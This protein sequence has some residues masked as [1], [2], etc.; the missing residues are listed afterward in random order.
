MLNKRCIWTLITIVAIG[1]LGTNLSDNFSVKASNSLQRHTQQEIIDYVEAH[2]F[3]VNAP[4]EYEVEPDLDNFN[5]GEISDK[6]KT[7]GINAINVMRY[8]AGLDEVTLDDDYNSLTAYGSMINSINRTLTHFPTQPDGMSDDIYKLCYKGTSSSNISYNWH[9]IA[10][11][12]I[13]CMQDLSRES[14][15]AHLGHRRWILYPRIGKIGVG[16]VGNYSC[17]YV[18]DK[19]NTDGYGVTGV[20]WPATNMP[21]DY[22]SKD[23]IWSYNVGKTVNMDDV[24]VTLV[25]NSGQSWTF[26]NNCSDGYFN[27]SNN[28]YGL[29]GC[30]I[31]RPDGITSYNDGDSYIVTITGVS[32]TDICYDVNFFSLG[33]TETEVSTEA[34]QSTQPVTQTTISATQSVIQTTTQ[35]TDVSGKYKY[36]EL[37]DGTIKIVS[38]IGDSETDSGILDIPSD[39]NGKPVTVLG[40]YS[41]S[42]RRW[43]TGI[44][45]PNTVKVIESYALQSNKFKSLVIP[46]S[47]VSIGEYAF[48]ESDLEYIQLSKNL[49]TLDK[50]AFAR[51]YKLKA[52]DIPESVQTIGSSVFYACKDLQYVV[53]NSKDCVIYDADYTFW[54]D[55]FC[56]IRKVIYCH[57]NSTAEDYAKKYQ[58]TYR[59]IEEAPGVYVP[60]YAEDSIFDLDLDAGILT[61]SGKGNTQDYE[62]FNNNPEWYLFRDRYTTAI[63]EDG[64]TGIGSGTLYD[65]FNVEH[66]ILPDS[67]RYVGFAPFENCSKL[68]SMI[69]PKNVEFVCEGVLYN[70]QNLEYTVFENKDCRIFDL[71]DTITDGVIYGFKNSTAE[72]YATKYDKPFKLLGDVNNNDVF[73]VADLVLMEKWLLSN[74]VEENINVIDVTNDDKVDSFDLIKYKQYYLMD[75]SGNIE[76]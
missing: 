53:V 74:N 21:T 70:C 38:Y 69:F 51:C 45:I 27:V 68:K 65:S 52:I 46:D 31:F 59:P 28:N 30:I 23:D 16:Q 76:F 18:F 35:V 54:G 44:H 39:I 3:D 36:T 57:E 62:Y 42:G 13:N 56:S 1:L 58:R 43:L 15:M 72:K 75:T 26:S 17:T 67:L 41:F 25:N 32:D 48:T 12:V 71:D 55:S 50:Y 37:D 22:F 11:A 49:E 24:K 33:K 14:N 7:D 64:I 73:S 8:I 2:P 40:S 10:N 4:I 20:K 19:S 6:L 60:G 47:V 5:P 63:F 66:I 61:I 9:N 34:T 29:P